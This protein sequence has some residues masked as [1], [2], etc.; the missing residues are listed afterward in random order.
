VLI[1]WLEGLIR[2][3]ERVLDVGTG[4]GILA[5][6]AIR[7][8]AR[9]AVGIDRDPVAIDCAKDYAAANGFG[10]ELELRV[11]TVRELDGGASRPFDIVLA[12]LDRRT[13]MDSVGFFE[14]YLRYGARLLLSGVLVEDRTQMAEL[15]SGVGGVVRAWRERDGWLALEIVTP[16]PCEGLS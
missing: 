2:G 15:F 3:G 1:E 8:G 10:P 14:P 11:A 12:N 6:L 4:S 7:L 13:F 16:E 5:M 9:S